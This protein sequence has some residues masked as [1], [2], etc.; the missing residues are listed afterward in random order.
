M[1]PGL[2][3]AALKLLGGIPLILGVT[4]VSFILMVYYGP[5]LTYELLG[6]NPSGEDIRA[7]RQ[8]L[9]YDQPFWLR[10]LAY[11]KELVTFDFGLSMVKDQPVSQM[12]E[13][14]IP[15]SLALMLPGFVLGNVLAVMLAMSAA[16]HRGQWLDKA[17]MSGAVLGMSISFLVVV[18]AFQ[19]IFASSY[20]L[21]WFP[22]RGWEVVNQHGDFSLSAYLSYV[23]VPTLATVFVS[24]GYNTRFYRAV[25]VEELNKDHITTAKAYGHQPAFIRY[26]YM[27]KN[28][29][30]PIITRVMFSIP[31]IVVSGSLLIESY[32]G[33]P[34]IGMVTYEAIM[35]GD[36]P[37]L[38]AVV[39]LTAVMFVVVLL[40]A[41]LL[42]RLADPRI[43]DPQ[44][45]RGV[46]P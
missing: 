40:V 30:I 17:I 26:R 12:L 5:D 1:N 35:A 9:G 18:V 37:V 31:M 11:L 19:V 22:V 24:L 15:V 43:S 42:Y 41:E 39:G 25:L 20:G 6:K 10:Y 2:R 36:Q 38:K 7:I 16:N 14:A 28:A 21:N 45:S 8:L 3:F 33:I 13:Q 29:L 23:T 34:G 32:F 27:L 46:T 44:K 4:L